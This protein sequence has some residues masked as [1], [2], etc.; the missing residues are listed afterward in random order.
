[1][2]MRRVSKPVLRE[3]PTR[4]PFVRERAP[5]HL[6]PLLSCLLVPP[7]EREARGVIRPFLAGSV[8]GAKSGFP[9]RHVLTLEMTAKLSTLELP[10][11]WKV[12]GRGGNARQAAQFWP[13]PLHSEA[14]LVR[15]S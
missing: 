9:V 15:R 14:G 13:V 7:T 6:L 4:R 12:E 1:M 10:C 2:K 8:R 5:D 11:S 3:F